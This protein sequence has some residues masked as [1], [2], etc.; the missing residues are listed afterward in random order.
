VNVIILMAGPSDKFS[1]AGY[2]YPKTLV[3]INNKPIV[4]I[5]IDN[6][7]PLI[8]SANKIIFV[9][10]KVDN[11]KFYLDNILKLLVPDAFLVEVTG[12]ISGAAVS[13]LLAIE[14]V[15]M[16]D[17][18]LILNGDQIIDENPLNLVNKLKD[19]D[20][21]TVVFKS[22]HPRWS[23]VKCDEDGFVVEAEEKKP[24]SNLATAG[25][26]YFKNAKKYYEYTKSMILKGAHIDSMFYVC[27]VFNEMILDQ[28]KINVTEINSNQ[29]HSLMD[30]E[31]VSIYEKFLEQSNN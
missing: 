16:L 31:M 1:E 19:F 7:R 3:E 14:K 30:S 21:G 18:L 25:F 23:Y 15:D 24:I 4:E 9:T 29:Y 28:K 20:G 8:T 26:Y 12:E 11:D 2:K 6:L 5:V 27:P 10:R 17:S 13:T 22:I